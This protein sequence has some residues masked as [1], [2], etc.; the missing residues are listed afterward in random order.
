[1]YSAARGEHTLAPLEQLLH[2]P[3]ILS[4]RSSILGYL[5]ALSCRAGDT[6]SAMK[7][8]ISISPYRPGMLTIH[9]ILT[10]RSD[11]KPALPDLSYAMQLLLQVGAWDSV[12]SLYRQSEGSL[13]QWC[14]LPQPL[15]YGLLEAPIPVKKQWC[16]IYLSQT[17]HYNASTD[18]AE[19][20]LYVA[21]ACSCGETPKIAQ[22]DEMALRRI[23]GTTA[24]VGLSYYKLIL[25]AKAYPHGISSVQIPWGLLVRS[26]SQT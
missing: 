4:E 23:G 13:F 9:H 12:L 18:C 14:K 25:A 7:W 17:P 3:S 5:W 2:N 22:S 20:L 26:A 11:I 15:Y 16:S 24:A 21:I 1:M 8:L 6:E 10:G 19:W